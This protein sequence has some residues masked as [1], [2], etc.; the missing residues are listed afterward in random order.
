MTPVNAF[1]CTMFF[2]MVSPP[3]PSDEMFVTNG[4]AVVHPENAAIIVAMIPTVA[5]CFILFIFSCSVVC[6][7]PQICQSAAQRKKVSDG[8][9]PPQTF[10]FHSEPDGWLPFAAPSGVRL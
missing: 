8:S 9:Q 2:S 3:L 10:A 1:R 5:M 6:C 4:P 7:F